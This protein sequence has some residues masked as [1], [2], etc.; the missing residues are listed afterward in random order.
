MRK[1]NPKLVQ[2]F[3]AAKNVPITIILGAEEL[4]AGNARLKVSSGGQEATAD[5]SAQDKGEKDRGQL[6]SR[7]REN[8]VDEVKNLLT[9]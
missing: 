6:V 5:G 4:A 7:E 9:L 2:Q 3:K 8:L 1:A